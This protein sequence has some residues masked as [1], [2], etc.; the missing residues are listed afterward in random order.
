MSAKDLGR[1]RP[2]LIYSRRCDCSGGRTSRG[3][4][5]LESHYLV[6]KIKTTRV[7][8]VESASIQVSILCNEVIVRETEQ[9]PFPIR[10]LVTVDGHQGKTLPLLV[11]QALVLITTIMDAKAV[12]LA[13]DVEV[14]EG[15][16]SRG[17]NA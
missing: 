12:E 9:E 13:V 3:Q 7:A 14:K 10:A 16:V 17:G 4:A 8:V 1:I 5:D 2:R 11:Q 6:I 15:A